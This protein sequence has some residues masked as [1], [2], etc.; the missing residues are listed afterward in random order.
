MIPLLFYPAVYIMI[1][2]GVYNKQLDQYEFGKSKSYQQQ[3]H[4]FLQQHPQHSANEAFECLITVIVL[5]ERQIT[6]NRTNTAGLVP[7]K[8]QLT[9][10]PATAEPH[11]KTDEVS[12]KTKQMLLIS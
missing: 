11:N 12:L 6:N 9:N 10:S 2:C 4:T 3:I 5:N 8:Q 7:N 1:K